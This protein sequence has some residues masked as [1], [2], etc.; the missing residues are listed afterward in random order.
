MM[1]VHAPHVQFFVCMPVMRWLNE[2][3]YTIYMYGE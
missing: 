2:G 3:L 1:P